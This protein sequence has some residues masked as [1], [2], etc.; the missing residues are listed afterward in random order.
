MEIAV[1]SDIHG[2]SWA[3][4]SVIE[5]VKR[6]NITTLFNLG[7]I[8]YGPLDPAGTLERLLALESV[9]V[10]NAVRGNHDRALL[11][12]VDRTRSSATLDYVRGQ[13]APD[14]LQWLQK[15][16]PAR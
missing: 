3:L 12:S 14:Q 11:E 15:I 5:D 4:D 9:M 8:T 6:R 1:L 7:D 13:L 2:N 10:V 16:P